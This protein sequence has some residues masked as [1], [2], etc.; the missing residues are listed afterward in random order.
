MI[1][2][3]H[4]RYY[5]THSLE[6]KGFHAFPK[7]IWPKVNAIARLELN[8][9]YYDSTVQHLISFTESQPL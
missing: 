2:E 5:L 8:N 9:A 4:Y 7:G 6:D 1:L 3:E